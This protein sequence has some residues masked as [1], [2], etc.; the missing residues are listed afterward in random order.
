MHLV[1]WAKTARGAGNIFSMLCWQV[2]SQLRQSAQTTT[3]PNCYEAPWLSHSKVKWWTTYVN[4]PGSVI[5][6]LPNSKSRDNQGQEMFLAS[7]AGKQTHNYI[8]LHAFTQ[9]C[10]IRIYSK[11]TFFISNQLCFGLFKTLLKTLQ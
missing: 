9:K 1:S 5:V 8:T 7:S 2:N 3:P 11:K 6:R 4:L 10:Q